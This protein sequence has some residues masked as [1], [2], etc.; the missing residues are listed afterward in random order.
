MAK[1]T[2][3]YD[4]ALLDQTDPTSG[5]P[6]VAAP[7][8]AEQDYGYPRQARPSRQKINYLFRAI[9]KFLTWFDTEEVPR[10]DGRITTEATTRDDADDALQG[11]LFAEI[12]NREAADLVL[13]GNID[14]VSGGLA[15]E[16]TTRGGADTILQ[17]NID[18]VQDNLDAEALTRSTADGA[19]DTRL[20]LYDGDTTEAS[21]TTLEL[22]GFTSNLPINWYAQFQR[23]RCAVVDLTEVALWLPSTTGTSTDTTLGFASASIPASLRPDVDQVAPIEVYDNNSLVM[24]ILTITTTGD[25][26]IRRWDDTGFTASGTKGLAPQ[27]IR[28]RKSMA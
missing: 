4:W 22:F 14:T 17:G 28:Y 25:W 5:Q 18:D 11:G 20:D 6:N 3:I 16:V 23:H 27:L 15:T 12:D 8:T 13:Q 7:S 1:P 10:L 26:E 19:L 2:E 9:G 21:G 24:G